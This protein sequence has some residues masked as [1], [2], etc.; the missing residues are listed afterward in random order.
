MTRTIGLRA[1]V[2]AAGRRLGIVA[3]VVAMDQ[4]EAAIDVDKPADLV[5]ADHILHQPDRSG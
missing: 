4:A 2:A 1:A 3:R 5:L